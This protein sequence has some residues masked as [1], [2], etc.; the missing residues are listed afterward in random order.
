[1]RLSGSPVAS[2]RTVLIVDDDRRLGQSMARD[3]SRRGVRAETASTLDE[4]MAIVRAHPIDVVLLDLLL[5]RDSSL[6]VLQAIRAASP[7]SR[8]VVLTGFASI[9]N[10]VEVTRLGASAYLCKPQTAGEILAA[11]EGRDAGASPG[12]GDVRGGR[13]LPSLAQH[14][15]EYIQRVVG[16]CKGNISEAARMLCINR[17]TLQRKLQK[18]V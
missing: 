15:R 13:V 1:M 6:D 14:E 3:F 9:A 10:A 2:V 8:V 5:E 17:R 18:Q 7:A 12:P 16:E 4:T 11:L